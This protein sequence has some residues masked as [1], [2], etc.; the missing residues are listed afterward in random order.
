VTFPANPGG[1]QAPYFNAGQCGTAA[2]GIA[3]TAFTL[4]A[5]TFDAHSNYHAGTFALNKRFSQ[6]FSFNTSFT[7]AKAISE[8]DTNNS[9]AILLGNASHSMDALNRHADRSEALISFR[10]RFTTNLIY[11][12][13]F[14]KGKKYM[15]GG[16]VADAILGGWALNLLGEARSGFPFS[17]LAGFGITGTG[18]NLTFPDRTNI[19]RKNPVVGAVTKYYDPK[20]YFLQTPGYYGTAARNSVVGPGYTSFDFGIGKRFQL[21]ERVNLQFRAEFFNIAN[22]ANFDIPFNQLYTP[23]NQFDHVPTQAELDGLPCTLTAGQAFVPGGGGTSCNPQAG[24]ITSTVG[25]PRQ[26]QFA[27]KLTF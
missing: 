5:V 4:Y 3:S 26:V 23:G 18:D 22:H 20:A 10:K 27:L 16:G 25:T 2:P 6:G 12:L 19:S 21:T 11:E 9:G 15:N 14:G 8:S 17:V 24:R 1:A 13:P 7:W